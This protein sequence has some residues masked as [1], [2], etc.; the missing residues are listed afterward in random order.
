MEVNEFLD[1]MHAVENLK[2]VTRHSWTSQGRHEDVAAHSWRVA[3]MAMMVSD[4][5]KE[6]DMNRVIKMCDS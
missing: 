6:L 4:E 2:Q 1:F 3:L 5:F